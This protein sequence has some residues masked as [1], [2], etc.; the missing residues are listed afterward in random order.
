MGPNNDSSHIVTD[1]EIRSGESGRGS[2][3]QEHV[4]QGGDRR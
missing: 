1:G 2:D 3:P 4:D